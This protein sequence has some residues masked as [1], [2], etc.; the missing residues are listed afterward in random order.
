MS[1]LLAAAACLTSVIVVLLLLLD[2][3]PSVAVVVVGRDDVDLF[4]GRSGLSVGLGSR[5]GERRLDVRVQAGSSEQIASHEGRWRGPQ[6]LDVLDGHKAFVA[7]AES[8]AEVSL[9]AFGLVHLCLDH[10]IQGAGPHAVRLE[11]LRLEG[12]QVQGRQVEVV[13]EVA[14]AVVVVH[15]E[16]FFLDKEV[17]LDLLDEEVARLILD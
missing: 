1:N 10:V 14:A 17:A 13:Q 6:H 9:A 8:E 3:V 4:V 15:L 7:F 11:G 16:N 5:G 12:R 2:E